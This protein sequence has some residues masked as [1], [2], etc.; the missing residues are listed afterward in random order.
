MTTSPGEAKPKP[1]GRTGLSLVSLAVVGLIF[2]NIL[3]MLLHHPSMVAPEAALSIEA[4]KLV[5]SGKVPYID[6]ICLI[7][8]ILLYGSVLPLSLAQV[9]NFA[10]S[11]AINLLNLLLAFAS[12]IFCANILLPK[13][14]HREW[15]IF[16]HLLMAL[17]VAN[18]LMLF[19]LGQSEQLFM[20]LFMPYVLVRWLRWNGYSI[21]KKEAITSGIAAAIGLSFGQQFIVFP[22]FLETLWLCSY[23]KLD[24]LIALEVRLCLITTVVYGLFLIMCTEPFT[25]AYLSTIWPI[26]GTTSDYYDM[27]MYGIGSM[28]ERRDIFYAGIAAIIFAIPKSNRSNL[29]LTLILMFLTGF[30]FYLNQ[31]TGLSHTA[32]PMIFSA[33]LL[34]GVNFGITGQK[35]SAFCKNKF[36]FVLL[37]TFSV[38][39]FAVTW[40]FL[41]HQQNFIAATFPTITDDT[42]G[43]RPIPADCASWLAKYSEKGDQVMFLTDDQLPGHPLLLQ[44]NRKPSGYFLDSSFLPWLDHAVH[45]GP[46]E[47]QYK[48]LT[49]QFYKRL[50]E[51]IIN[52]KPKM[53]FLQEGT[54]HDL[55][56]KNEVMPTIDKNYVWKGAA[57]LKKINDSNMEPLE[58]HG[59]L[60]NVGVFVPKEK[61][62]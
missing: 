20:L 24:P 34:W 32:I 35:L 43:E 21:T 54:M 4:A 25:G 16:P 29:S 51:D 42:P 8:P 6:F 45:P 3:L 61:T 14:H 18:A 53:I 60:Y 55:M 38:I 9:L 31:P 17:A 30:W 56:N 39:V 48:R 62:P 47:N 28:P 12:T 46:N 50:K 23:I 49:E 36:D 5:V 19:Q 10:P 2:F 52:Q 59:V 41:A 44:M 27:A 11:L 37:C 7:S 13:K 33:T 15:Q 40:L 1:I 22:L 58:Y 57:R 26:F